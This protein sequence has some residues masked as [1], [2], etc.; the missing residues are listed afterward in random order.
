MLGQSV[1]AGGQSDYIRKALNSNR[2]SA[3]WLSLGGNQKWPSGV[4]QWYYSPSGQPAA[5][6]TD[7]VVA[8]MKTAAARWER[9][10]NVTIQYM[11]LTNVAPETEIAG[12]PDYVNVWGWKAFFRSDADASAYSLSWTSAD[13]SR[14][15]DSD[16][17]MNVL[18]FWDIAKIDGVMTHE[19][20]HS[21]G[22]DHSNISESVMYANPYHSA[23]YIRTLR[24]DDAIGCA[25]LYG[26]NP[27][28]MVER[29]M[30]WA[31]QAYASVLYN[32]G[33]APTAIKDGYQYRYY[34]YSK[35]YAM[36]K[37]GRAYY[38]DPTGA[39]Q[40]LGPVAN[41]ETQVITAGF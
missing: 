24:G 7:D 37:D 27:N 11:G 6:S 36:S 19:I 28:A 31:E 25:S 26:S 9:M 1:Y 15:V 13:Y 3:Q 39:I 18:E 2:E 30:N 32:L 22:L 16:I 20:G 5:L 12:Q 8:A 41:F 33:P 35:N 29:T 14:I 4:Y 34:Q 10:C 23:S 17:V 40:D 38:V 21:L